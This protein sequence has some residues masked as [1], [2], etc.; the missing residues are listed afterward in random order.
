MRAGLGSRRQVAELVEHEQRV[1][2]GSGEVAVAGGAFL[3]AMGRADAGI[4]AERNGARRTP[5]VNAVDP[6]SS[7]DR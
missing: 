1:V 7:T 6:V 2:A 5:A 3:I 4:H